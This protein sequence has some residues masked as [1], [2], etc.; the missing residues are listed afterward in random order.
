MTFWSSRIAASGRA[1]S[2]LVTTILI[3]SAC[4][5]GTTA[6]VAA[7]PIAGSGGAPTT[8]AGLA[9]Y[10]GADRQQILGDGDPVTGRQG[11]ILGD[12]AHGRRVEVSGPKAA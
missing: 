2:A 11:Q 1:A 5:G 4:G 8:P 12:D 3:A 9:A 10:R 7:T 6:P